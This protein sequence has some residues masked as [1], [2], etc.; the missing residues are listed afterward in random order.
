MVTQGPQRAWRAGPAGN[1]VFGH[2]LHRL[3]SLPAPP[4]PAG[5]IAA[6]GPQSFPKLAREPQVWPGDTA[7]VVA[8]EPAVGSMDIYGDGERGG[9]A[10]DK[11][12]P[13][14]HLITHPS[15]S[16]GPGREEDSD[17]STPPGWA[18]GAGTPLVAPCEQEGVNRRSGR[19]L[20]QPASF[21]LE[22]T[23]YSQQPC[24]RRGSLSPVLQV[25]TEAPA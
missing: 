1:S 18:E 13:S 19:Y 5:E 21:L 10:L 20:P 23:Q 24:C 2:P 14:L 15:C 9:D 17:P 22:F 3:T 6:A 12:V 11:H 8:A 7:G 25:E 4:P 16:L